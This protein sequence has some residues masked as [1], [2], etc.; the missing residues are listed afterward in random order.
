MIIILITIL[1]ILS[2]RR[3]QGGTS[4]GIVS[5]NDNMKTFT[6]STAYVLSKIIVDHI[7]SQS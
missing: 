6:L 2:C 1:I 7:L 3:K 5:L 4:T